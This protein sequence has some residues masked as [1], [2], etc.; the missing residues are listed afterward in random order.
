LEQ[1][2][3]VVA[4]EGDEAIVSGRRANS[5]GDCAGKAS[6]STLGSWK[7][8]FVEMRVKNSIFAHVGDEVLLELPDA[9][10]L[11]VAFRLYGLPMLAFVF[12]G[13]IVRSVALSAAWPL[14]EVWAAA[15]GVLGVLA[16]YGWILHRSKNAASESLNARMVRVTQ[17]GNQFPIK[18]VN[19]ETA[20]L[21]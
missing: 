21:H 10:L 1:R 3:T 12:S 17:P 9:V 4:I 13:L 15:A 11:R 18:V 14:P 6:C 5:C 7:D 2:V 16:T 20:Q 8:R 19:E